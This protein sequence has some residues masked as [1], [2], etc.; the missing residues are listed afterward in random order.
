MEASK[1]A[2]NSFLLATMKTKNKVSK[3]TSAKSETPLEQ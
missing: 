2:S 3:K 1:T